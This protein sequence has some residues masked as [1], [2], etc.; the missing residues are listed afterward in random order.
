MSQYIEFFIH[1]VWLDPDKPLSGKFYPLDC[2]SR[3]NEVY[4]VAVN[5]VP[6]GKITLLNRVIPAIKETIE[7]EIKQYARLKDRKTEMI[8]SVIHFSDM[9]IEDRIEAIEE[10]KHQIEEI[11]ETIVELEFTKT[12][13]SILNGFDENLQIYVGIEVGEPS[14]EDII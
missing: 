3:S 1:P 7:T 12:F 4:Q 2:Y 9:S 6:Y 8:D 11:N 14:E 10:Y 5:H 13:Y